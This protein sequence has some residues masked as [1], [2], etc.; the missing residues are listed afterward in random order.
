MEETQSQ[1]IEMRPNEL[2]HR[3]WRELFSEVWQLGPDPLDLSKQQCS[4][5]FQT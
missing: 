3:Q 4:I 5:N 1:E 2:C